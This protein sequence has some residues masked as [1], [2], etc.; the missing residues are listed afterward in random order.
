MMCPDISFNFLANE[1]RGIFANGTSGSSTR[2]LV[3]KGVFQYGD[4]FVSV[5]SSRGDEEN[6]D[7][8]RSLR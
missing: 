5:C 3:E 7:V 2:A 1:E 4:G 8:P 6:V